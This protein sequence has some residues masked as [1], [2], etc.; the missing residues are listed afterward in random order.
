MTKRRFI[1]YPSQA[2]LKMPPFCLLRVLI[3]RKI[4]RRKGAQYNTKEVG[5]L[6]SAAATLMVSNKRPVTDK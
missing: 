3:A 4:L 6:L 2:V 1:A 5:H